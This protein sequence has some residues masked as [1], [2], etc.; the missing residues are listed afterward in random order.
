[1]RPVKLIVL[2]LL[3]TIASIT[4]CKND[5]TAP[6]GAS[7]AQSISGDTSRSLLYYALERTGYLELASTS[8][9][10]TLFAPDNNAFRAEGIFT[11]E[12]VDALDLTALKYVI[13]YHLAGRSLPV[14]K[15]PANGQLQTLSNYIFTSNT[16]KGIFIN[17]TALPSNYEAAANG[18]VY[19][20]SGLLVPPTQTLQQLINADTSLTFFNKAIAKD[21]LVIFNS[22]TTFY[23]VLA[24][25]NNAFRAV[26]LN[27]IEAVEALS[28]DSL[29][30]IIRYHV[31]SNSHL[32][33]TDFVK[34]AQYK[35][36][37]DSLL[38]TVTDPAPQ[39]VAG[40]PKGQTRFIDF[41]KKD[42]IAINGVI[43]RVDELLI[44]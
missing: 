14:N 15:I 3:C 9:N 25:V 8:P 19:K 37:R 18:V 36:M 22:L 35:N 1:M 41:I 30:K 2:V 4:G 31:I 16:A 6:P 27:S 40:Y 24:P 12:D 20:I 10:I 43:H 42:S 38:I 13:G 28:R 33:T 11:N 44:P 23:T 7:V 32:L 26:N 5:L 34:D 17:A 21:T 39:F 29:G